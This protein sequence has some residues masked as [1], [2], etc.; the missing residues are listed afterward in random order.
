MTERPIDRCS[1]PYRVRFDEAG[2][3]GL[4]RTSVLLRYAQDLAWY[5][6]AQRGFDRAWYAARGLT[7][8]VRAAQVSV[9]AP[10]LVGDELVGTTWAVGQRRVWARRRSEFHGAGELVGWTD[11]DWLLLDARGS[12]ARI[13]PEFDTAFGT[14]PT[15]IGL[16]RVDLGET[17]PDARTSHLRLRPQ[18]QDPMGHAN[19]AAYADWLEEAV[20]DAGDD[21]AVRRIPRTAR[22][23]Y[24]RAAE[25]GVDLTACSWRVADGWAFR[26]AD[27]DDAD[28][29]RAR[30]EPRP[31]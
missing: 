26:L 18:E 20:I 8:L 31:A 9:L 12:P 7:W 25:P 5:H 30:L 4:L 10:V 16:A 17:P 22:L 19:N 3:D 24:A 29:L 13:P 23:E 6:A 11:I 14:P 27:A 2:P 15:A 28:L 1:A 21:A